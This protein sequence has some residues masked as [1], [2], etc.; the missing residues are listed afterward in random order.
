VKVLT[1]GTVESLVQALATEPDAKIVAGGTAV[2]L[3]LKQGLIAPECLVSLGRIPD[4]QGVRVD[5]RRLTILARTSLTE[6][7]HHPEVRRRLPA[8]ADACRSV[9]SVRIRNAATIGGNIAEADYA[10]DPPAM[11]IALGA[12]VTIV[13]PDGE[14]QCSVD[15]LITGFYETALGQ[16]EVITAVHFPLPSGEQRQVY[17]KYRSRSSEDRPCVGVGAVAT[18]EED[19]ATVR[20]LSVAVGAA[21]ARPRAFAELERAAI[22]RTLDTRLIEEIAGGYGDALDAISDLRA[23]SWYRKQMTRVFVT[24]ALEAIALPARAA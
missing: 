6:V 23:T 12:S 20:S 13:G 10:S 14:R 2:V 5:D 1:P 19:G 18:F 11:M 8:F 17:L 3:M 4:L 24:R 9:G 7:A 15:S 16:A 22:G 21:C